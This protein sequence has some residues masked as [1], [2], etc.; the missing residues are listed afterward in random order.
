MRDGPVDLEHRLHAAGRSLSY[1]PTP[2][3]AVTVVDQLPSPRPEPRRPI[4][5][6]ALAVG[7][8]AV[9]VVGLPGPRRAVA[10]LLG[11]GG[12]TLTIVDELPAAEVLPGWGETATLDEAAG[13]VAF[14]LVVPDGLGGPDL[15]AVDRSV[16]GGL[17]TLGFGD[18]NSISL[19]ITQMAGTT[20]PVVTKE[21][22]PNVEIVLVTVG[23][24]RGLWIEG[25]PHVVALRR[26]DGSV[27]DQAP[28]L[29]ANTLIYSD[30]V[31][32]IRIELAGSLQDAQAVA[33]LLR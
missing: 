32:T 31:R 8:V 24:G 23:G 33:E 11:I 3:L 6:A 12:V 26:S 13:A 20:E 10:D 9:L 14:D 27:S 17:V 18:G 21:V 22:S 15:V 29:V 28:R 30:G 2:D 16:P 7:L 1:P 5:A 19:V 25:P 4:L